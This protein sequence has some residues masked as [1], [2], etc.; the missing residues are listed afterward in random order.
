MSELRFKNFEMGDFDAVI[1]LWQAAGII[2][3]RSDTQT[4]LAQKLERD[5]DLFFIMTD[6]DNQIIGCVMGTFDG[7]RGW[8]NHLAI[9]PKRQGEGLGKLMIRQLEDRFRKAGCEKV[10]LLIEPTNSAVQAFYER[11]DYTEDKLIFMEKWL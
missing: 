3:S 8:I 11:I 9:D 1:A 7:R 5:P 6:A 2:L 10:N 4:G